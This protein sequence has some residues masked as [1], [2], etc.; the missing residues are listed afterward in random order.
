MYSPQDKQIRMHMSSCCPSAFPAGCYWYATKR[1]S[2]GR[3]PKWVQK[4][5]DADEKESAVK[6][7]L[8]SETEM[9]DT[10]A[11]DLSEIEM[12]GTGDEQEHESGN[13]TDHKTMT[14]TTTANCGLSD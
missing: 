8:E 5:L 2:P 1:H 3:P 6:S 14:K 9:D 10:Q 13:E 11:K 7:E 4:L 12:E